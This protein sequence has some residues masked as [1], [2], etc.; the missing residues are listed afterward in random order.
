MLFSRSINYRAS[1][2]F[3][4]SQMPLFIWIYPT[5]SVLQIWQCFFSLCV[6][7]RACVD[8]NTKETFLLCIANKINLPYLKSGVWSPP[9]WM[10]SASS[11]PQSFQDTF[12]SQVQFKC[13]FS[14]LLNFVLYFFDFVLRVSFKEEMHDFIKGLYKKKYHYSKEVIFF[15]FFARQL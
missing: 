2:I 3:W 5:Q 7:T 11:C 14:Q 9:S 15:P 12:F 10:P 6:C 8:S 13:C 1:T 4:P